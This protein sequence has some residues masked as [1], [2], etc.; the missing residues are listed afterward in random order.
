[1]RVLVTGGSGRLARHVFRAGARSGIA[2][3]VLSRRE[4]ASVEG[5]EWAVGDLA[6]GAGLD[7]ALRGVKAVLHLASDPPRAARADVEGT[8]HL[9]EACD[10]ARVAHLLYLSIIGIDA[11][12][13][14]Y[15]RH[16]LTAEALIAA[17]ATPW[18]I[19]RAAQFHS[20]ID[21]LFA[22]AARRIAMFLPA[23]WRVQSVDDTEVAHRLLDALRDGPR[24]RLRDY[25]GPEVFVA[26]E[27]ARMWRR[28]RGMRKPVVP[29]PVF[30]AVSAGFR[31]GRNTAPDGDRGRVTWAEWLRARYGDRA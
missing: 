20:F 5:V 1:M 7:D 21:S 18:S 26:S 17:G 28:A 3:R 29:V 6:T 16:K 13:N 12:P 9:V 2:F 24:G 14:P 10:R 15:Y 30:G 27:A 11:I 19:L 23:G 8:R 4:T 31:A 22:N 25:A